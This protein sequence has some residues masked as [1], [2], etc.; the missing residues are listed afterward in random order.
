MLLGNY[1]VMH[2]K[3]LLIACEQQQTLLLLHVPDGSPAWPPELLSI[4][5]ISWPSV[6]RGNWTRVDLFCCILGCLLYCFCQYQSSD[7]LWRPPPK[8]L[9]CSG[10]LNFTPTPTPR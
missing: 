7:W 3:C 5:L 10:A 9:T 6:T 4:H 8:W 2:K 1:Y